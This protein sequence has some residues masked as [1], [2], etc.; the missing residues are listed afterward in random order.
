MRATRLLTP[1]R[2]LAVARMSSRRF[3]TAPA[4]P[5]TASLLGVEDGVPPLTDAAFTAAADASA[6]GTSTIFTSTVD[7][8]T[9]V[10]A[11]GFTDA[12]APA[13]DAAASGASGLDASAAASAASAASATD[14]PSPSALARLFLPNVESGVGASGGEAVS[15]ADTSLG[16]WPPDLAL[17]LVDAVHS[18]SELPWWGAIAA[19]AL[20]CRTLLLPLALYGTRLG[21]RMQELKQPVAELQ[22]RHAGGGEGA[23][24][25]AAAEL[26][27]LY[28]AHGVSP[29][30]M[31]ALPL[32]QLPVFLS[33]FVGLKRL[34]ETFPAAHEGG[35]Y[36]FVDLGIADST[37]ALPIASGASALS[38]V[39]LSLPPPPPNA[40]LLETQQ[41]HNYVHNGLLTACRLLVNLVLATHVFRHLVAILRADVLTY[42]LT[43]A[44]LTHRSRRTTCAS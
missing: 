28:A 32:V 17:R 40:T 2:H 24:A 23:E 27:E 34:C 14:T 44:R 4:S 16:V 33:F 5:V 7:A 30:R 20:L 31:L 21:A 8:A 6:T 35:T 37:F 39:M 36:W 38:L 18:G 1:T 11:T 41:A 26:Q 9:A 43:A 25:A 19:S 42:L 22:A 3:A 10:T 13:T 15:L 12:A 29:I